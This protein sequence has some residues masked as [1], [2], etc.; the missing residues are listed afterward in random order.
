MN[1]IY[2]R[3]IIISFGIPATARNRYNAA[4]LVKKERKSISKSSR[5]RGFRSEESIITSLEMIFSQ[6]FYE[7]KIEEFFLCYSGPSEGTAKETL[8]QRRSLHCR[9]ILDYYTY[10]YRIVVHVSLS[11]CH[12]IEPAL[13]RNSR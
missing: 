6:S 10:T 11:Y 9:S 13:Y 3:L 8:K 12:M 2:T 5:I 4:R 1:T 7:K